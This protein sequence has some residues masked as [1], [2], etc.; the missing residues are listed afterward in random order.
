[1]SKRRIFASAVTKRAVLE[2]VNE[3]VRSAALVDAIAQRSWEAEFVLDPMTSKALRAHS[4]DV[5]R[6]LGKLQRLLRQDCKGKEGEVR[7]SS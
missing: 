4:E 7:S 3:A 6:V 1:M 2:F 5:A